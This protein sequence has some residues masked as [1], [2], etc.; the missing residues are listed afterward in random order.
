MKFT[1]RK[2]TMFLLVILAAFVLVGCEKDPEPDNPDK[3]K[4]SVEVPEIVVS[5]EGAVVADEEADD[6]TKE[7][8][9]IYNANLGQFYSYYTEALEE[10]NVSKRQALMAIAEAKL[11]ESGTFLPLS[12]QGGNY[13]ISRVAPYS[14][15]SVL[16]GN[17]SNRYHSA[18]VTD[19]FITATDRAEMKAHYSQVKGTGAYYAWAKEFLSGKGYSFSDV[20]NLAYTE[21]PVTWDILATSSSEDSDKI[22]HTYDGLY[23][24]DVENEL[25]PAIA[26]S[27]EVSADGKTYTFKIREGVKWVNYQGQEI[28]EVT[29]DDFVAGMQHM[30]DV[31]GGLEYL[32]QGVIVNA[33]EYIN[34]EVTDF[35]QVGV[36]AVDKYTLQYTLV[37]AKSYFMTMLGYGV[38][39]PMSRT[40]YE[41]QGGKFGA[42]FD[43]S[44]ETYLYGVDSEHIAYC[45]P[46]LVAEHTSNSV[47]KFTA[48]PT[49]WN[50][51]NCSIK[52]INMKFNDGTD[53][54]K[55]YEDAKS[56]ALAGAGLNSSAL[57]SAKIE[58]PSGEDKTYFELYGYV[59]GT[60]ATTF[61]A[62]INMNRAAFANVNDGTSAASSKTDAQKAASQKALNNVY[63]R[64]ALC[65]SLDRGAYNAQTVGEELKLTSLRNSYVPGTFVA[66]EEE[67]T[68]KINGVDTKFAKGTNYGVI[69]QAQL[70]AD[71]MPIKAYDASADDGAGSSDGYDGWY[72]PE[73]AVAFLEKA[74]EQ[75]SAQGVEVSAANPIVIDVPTFTGSSIYLNRETAFKQSVANVLGGKVVINLVECN[76]QAAWLYAGYRTSL[77]SEA[78]Y[79]IY[80]V[81]G[82]G[83]DYGDPQTY[84]DTM[85]PLYA[86]YMTKCLGVY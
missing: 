33:D 25:K 26:E 19:K 76:T 29:A 53:A 54:K 2:F 35:S 32:V 70:D 73:A 13:A 11:L 55:A 72:N 6:Y 7:S 8:T 43:S 14:I 36:K 37:E 3:P 81:S 66:L 39:A 10:K 16:W 23:E 40:Y 58:K 47:I 9:E 17:D 67:V 57:E 20:Y 28:G 71:K 62:F 64:L 65:M 84:L 85:L 34:G 41:S 4:P 48:N 38:F 60:D 18:I 24:Y 5:K 42:E 80:D 63:F 46:Y 21:E 59:S 83:P 78:N 56:N 30:M 45:G 27:Y 61:S 31:A 79:D 68:V 1:M 69:L 82:W 44:A 22:I 74:I 49:Y 12:S 50:A 75:L 15:S 52:T 77:G 51:A 86:G